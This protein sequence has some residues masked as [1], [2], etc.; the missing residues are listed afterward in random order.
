MSGPGRRASSLLIS[1]CRWISLGK[2]LSLSSHSYFVCKRENLLT[3]R[4]TTHNSD[5][6]LQSNVIFFS[7]VI[8]FYFP[9][10]HWKKASEKSQE[11][12]CLWVSKGN[13]IMHAV[14][15]GDGLTS[16]YK[17]RAAIV[18]LVIFPISSACPQKPHLQIF[19][20]GKPAPSVF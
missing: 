20:N 17:M 10:L 11:I 18:Y 9:D 2:L 13:Q 14:G 7:L 15:F 3:S 19:M 6:P 5:L 1:G 12:K 4:G 16:V 8:L